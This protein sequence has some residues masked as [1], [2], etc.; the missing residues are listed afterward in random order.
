MHFSAVHQLCE[1]SYTS[2]NFLIKALDQPL[3]A[4]L[5]SRLQVA[6]Q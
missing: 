1:K 4:M 3:A 5:Y 2:D 6:D